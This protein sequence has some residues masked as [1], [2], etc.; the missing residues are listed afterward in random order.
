MITWVITGDKGHKG[1]MPFVKAEEGLVSKYLT[2]VL[3]LSVFVR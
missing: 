2:A 3:D 1:L